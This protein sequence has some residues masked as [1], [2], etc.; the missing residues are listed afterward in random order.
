MFNNFKYL[1]AQYVRENYRTYRMVPSVSKCSKLYNAI[2]FEILLAI[3]NLQIAIILVGNSKE[4]EWFGFYDF[5]SYLFV[6]LHLTMIYSWSKKSYK[7]IGI[8]YKTHILE[9]EKVYENLPPYIKAKYVDFV[10]L[11]YR[12]A[13]RIGVRSKYNKGKDFDL[14]C[15]IHDLFLQSE[16]TGGKESSKKLQKRIFTRLEIENEI[17]RL[18][19]IVFK[20]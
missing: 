9:I 6:A 1:P 15:R 2:S 18:E 3:V 12:T 10:D 4:G 20:F 14:I 7:M 11:A 5:I 19:E 17:R 16:W 13:E 8:L